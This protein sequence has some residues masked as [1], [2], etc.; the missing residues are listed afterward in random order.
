MGIASGL[1]VDFQADGVMTESDLSRPAEL[2]AHKLPAAEL[3][4]A[5]SKSVSK[6]QFEPLRHAVFETHLD[7]G[8]SRLEFRWNPRGNLERRA[9]AGYDRRGERPRPL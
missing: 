6:T 1:V 5:G 7:G 2:Y 4:L 8:R 9:V 3:D